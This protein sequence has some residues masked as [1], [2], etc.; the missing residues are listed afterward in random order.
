MTFL[1]LTQTCH[2]SDSFS[3]FIWT[4]TPLLCSKYWLLQMDIVHFN[5]FL[6][7]VTT[8]SVTITM[9]SVELLILSPS[10]IFLRAITTRFIWSS[11]QYRYT[12]NLRYNSWWWILSIS[13]PCRWFKTFWEKFERFPLFFYE[14]TWNR[15]VYNA[16]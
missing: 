7:I 8:Q 11:N 1:I 12:L 3:W 13:R 9:I 2:F 4:I 10:F 6:Y 16:I 5:F 15:W 14:V